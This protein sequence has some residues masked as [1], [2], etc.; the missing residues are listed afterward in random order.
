MA[1]IERCSY[2]GGR[3]KAKIPEDDDAVPAAKRNEDTPMQVLG[4]PSEA[5]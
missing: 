1:L 3:L 4:M 2:A 5:V